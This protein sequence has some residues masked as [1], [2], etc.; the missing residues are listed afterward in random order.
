[1]AFLKKQQLPKV[2]SF[3]H[4]GIDAGDA[5]ASVVVFEWNDGETKRYIG[6][7]TNEKKSDAALFKKLDPQEK[8]ALT[9][10]LS[11]DELW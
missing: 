5:K 1:M 7:G 2:A 11:G 10:A 4:L 8:S 6:V 9:I 3:K